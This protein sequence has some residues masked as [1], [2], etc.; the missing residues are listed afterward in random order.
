[1]S[2]GVNLYAYVFANPLGLIDP[3]GLCVARIVGG[4]IEV[5]AAVLAIPGTGFIGT[6][7]AIAVIANGIDNII[8]GTRGLISGEYKMAL[9]EALV[10]KIVPE[11]AAPWV[12]AATQ[13]LIP[14]GGLK[15]AQASK[16]GTS[17]GLNQVKTSQS[18][19]TP[20]SANLPVKY[21]PK[22]A[23]K[24]MGLDPE[25]FSKL[26]PLRQEYVT[27]VVSLRYKVPIMRESGMSSEQ[28]ARALHAERR[29]LGVKYKNLTPA[30][31]L[32]RIQARNLRVY[33]DE[34]GP[35]IDW[36]RARGKTWDDIIESASRP[37]GRDLGY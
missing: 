25:H 1:M 11:G 29:A 6:A 7:A 28:I 8:A 23:A 37:G 33:N 18:L 21:D 15:V 26:P 10:Y 3:E 27:N 34:L 9:L 14:A 24:Q 20:T 36:L 5:V 17:G 2:E 12:Y 22:F 30:D 32:A 16:V 13:I 19:D 35:S 4:V 31:E